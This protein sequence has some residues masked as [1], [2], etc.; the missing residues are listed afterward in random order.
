LTQAD[1]FDARMNGSA[2]AAHNFGGYRSAQNA[3]IDI[4]QTFLC[5]FHAPPFNPR[6]NACD[7]VLYE[8][9]AMDWRAADE[10]QQEASW[11]VFLMF[12]VMAVLIIRTGLVSRGMVAVLPADSAPQDAAPL[13]NHQPSSTPPADLHRATLVLLCLAEA[14]GQLFILKTRAVWELMNQPLPQP[15]QQRPL[16]AAIM[17]EPPAPRLDTS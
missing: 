17:C 14:A 8:G 9:N 16:N 6:D 12:V 5:D 4:N 2:V 15:A 1:S 10:Q 3:A 13:V 11:R 7:C